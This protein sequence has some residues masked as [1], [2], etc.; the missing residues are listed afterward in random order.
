MPEAYRIGKEPHFQ[1]YYIIR[2]KYP[3]FDVS[4][5]KK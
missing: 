1:N 2:F 4:V 5:L 3:V